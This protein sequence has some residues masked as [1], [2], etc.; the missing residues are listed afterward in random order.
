VVPND[1]QGQKKW[2]EK[3]SRIHNS[4][5]YLKTMHFWDLFNALKED[6]EFYLVH[7]SNK[8]WY[9][10]AR[11]LPENA[12]MVPYYEEGK[13]DF[14]ILDVDQQIV[15]PNLGKTKIFK[16]LNKTIQDIP[17][18][19]INHG[20]PV[21]PE[22]CK[23]DDGKMTD[24]DAERIV[25]NGIKEMV[26][27]MPTVTNSHEA[28]SEREW[29]WG[30]PIW[31]GMN[32]DDWYDMPKEPRV[33]TAL[34]PGGCD[35]YYNREAMNE[36][37]HILGE[38]YGYKLWWAKVNVDTGHS[39]DDY[40]KY[41]GSSLIYL[42]TSFRTPMNRARTE[43]MLSGSCIVQVEGA[44]DLERFITPG[45]DMIIVPNNVDVIADMLV[46]LIE[47]HYKDCIEIGQRGKKTA[48]KIFNYKRYREDWLNFIHKELK[49]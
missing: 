15:N 3:I 10:S 23:L 26:G 21:Y 12:Q 36:V 19:V 45:E 17:K 1:V 22:Y 44:H 7:N 34:S 47:N 6:C 37:S 35:E 5:A 4:L 42:D 24:A 30:T 18:M 2:K 28:A 48:R 31:H 11:P 27:D 33:F 41:L 39:F 29:G 40:R 16:E 8:I 13:Y 49:I 14:A 25:R 43:A 20:S 9:T 46:D 32:P 38:K